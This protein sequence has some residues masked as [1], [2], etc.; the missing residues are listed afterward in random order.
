M[1][2]ANNSPLNQFSPNSSGP[3]MYEIG[4]NGGPGGAVSNALRQTI[5]RY[6]S[7]LDAQQEQASRMAQIAASSQ[8]ALGNERSM[9]DYKN[10]AELNKTASINAL[11]KTLPNSGLRTVDVGG[12]TVYLQDQADDSGRVVTKEVQPAPLMTMDQILAQKMQAA[13]ANG[14]GSPLMGVP[15]V[16]AS[17]MSTTSIPVPSA[18][19]QGD[20]K[21]QSAIQILQKAGKLVNEDTI[22]HV[23]KQI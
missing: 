5:D 12:R 7:N 21:R 1:I 19:G 20:V 13:D 15:P 6:H 2:G 3:S 17:P 11:N 10:T 9:V 4:L 18:V 14:G 22:N 16:Q 8:A 23:M